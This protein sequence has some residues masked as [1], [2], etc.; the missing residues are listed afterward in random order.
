MSC[1]AANCCNK[2]RQQRL[3]LRWLSSHPVVAR[4]VPRTLADRQVKAGKHP[5]LQL[6]HLH[7]ST[8]LHQ[9][10]PHKHNDSSSTPSTRTRDQLGPEREVDAETKQRIKSTVRQEMQ[11][12]TE[13]SPEYKQLADDLLAGDRY[14]LSRAITLVES[15]THQHR[16]QSNH[17][18]SYCLTKRSSATN[19]KRQLRIG[20]TG[21]PGVGKSTFIEAIGNYIVNECKLKLAVLSIDPSSRRTGGSILGDKTRMTELSRAENAFIRPSPSGGQLGGVASGTADAL[22]LVEAAGYDVTIIETVGVGQ[23]EVSVVDMVD[24]FVLLVAPAG[25]DELQGIKK[26]E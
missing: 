5:H 2:A 17:L 24:M 26:G 12:M 25:G 20:I 3:P 16:E 1:I 11:K 21:T 15:S 22:M 13:L 6:R 23:S 8:S 18:L 10:R 14:A 4:Q 7:A 19:N 9:A